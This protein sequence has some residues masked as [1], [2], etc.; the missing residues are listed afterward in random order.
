MATH[1]VVCVNYSPSADGTHY[2]I[3][4]LGVGSAAGWT[5]RVTVPQ[6]ITQLRL[7]GGDRYYTISSSTGVRAEVVEGECERCGMKPYVRT[8]ADGILDNNLSKLKYC[9]VS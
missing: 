9:Q 6:A 1:Q 2:H 3:T 8:T 4:D 7:P 5:Q